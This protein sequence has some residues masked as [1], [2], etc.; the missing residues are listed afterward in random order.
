MRANA[1]K[2]E[3]RG[4]LG[5]EEADIDAHGREALGST[6]DA[7]G[8]RV[9]Q[10]VAKQERPAILFGI[11]LQIFNDFQLQITRCQSHGGDAILER[12]H[13]HR[14]KF[15]PLINLGAG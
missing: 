10:I 12:I 4:G 13:L 8:D 11:G 3:P 14:I 1:C 5:P 6:I 9:L 7:D 15:T 2:N